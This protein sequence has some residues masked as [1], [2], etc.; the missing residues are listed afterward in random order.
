VVDW[1]KAAYPAAIKIKSDAVYI[2]N[3]P[4]AENPVKTAQDNYQVFTKLVKAKKFDAE[5]VTELKVEELKAGTGAVV[6]ESDI[7]EANYTGWNAKGIIF[8]TTKR[9]ADS[10]ATPIEFPLSDV[11]PGWTKGL[12]G[13]KVG[14]IYKLT[15]PVDL[16]Y[17]ETPPTKDSAGPLQFVIEIVAKK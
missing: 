7:I 8:D 10:A 4:T 6:A 5:K 17:G 1:L 2:A 9:T 11:I 13:K 12:A 3:K 14:G 16:A 15:I